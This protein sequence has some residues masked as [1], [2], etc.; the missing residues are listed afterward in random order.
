MRHVMFAVA[1]ALIS[2]ACV[3]VGTGNRASKDPLVGS[4]AGTYDGD[5]TG[6]FTM[7][8]SARRGKPARGDARGRAGRRRGLHGDIQVNHVDGNTVVMAYD[9]PDDGGR[10]DSLMAPSTARRSR[11]PG[12]P[13]TGTGNVVAS[14]GFTSSKQ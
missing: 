13:S 3:A 5:G 10:G 2:A 14:G 6:K 7:S 8:I 9:S 1:V 11:A 4:W 12:R